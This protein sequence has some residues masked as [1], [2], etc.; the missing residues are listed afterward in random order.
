MQGFV[1]LRRAIR[2]HLE[3]GRITL[4]EYAVFT[5][6]LINAHYRTGIWHGCA[7][8]LGLHVRKSER[9]C[10]RVLAR[11]RI[12]GYIFAKPSNGRG[13]YSIRVNKYFNKASVVT[14]SMPEGVCGD[15]LTHQKASVVTPYKEVVQEQHLKINTAQPRRGHSSEL[16]RQIEAKQKRLEQEAVVAAE[17][18]AG[19]MPYDPNEY[20]LARM[21]EDEYE[22]YKKDLL[23]NMRFH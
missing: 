12:K 2:E 3:D 6:L 15:T 20:F 19:R 13:R 21:S 5:V 11:L 16:I 9:W 8:V 10:Q 23:A 18:S 22:Q 1:K 4:E 17:A 7:L 14:P